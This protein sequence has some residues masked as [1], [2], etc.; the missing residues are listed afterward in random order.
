[1]CGTSAGNRSCI[2]CQFNTKNV[3]EFVMHLGIRHKKLLDFASEPMK[4]LF[5][6]LVGVEVSEFMDKVSDNDMDEPSED[7]LSNSQVS[8]EEEED[9]EGEE[10][11]ED[12]DE[13]APVAEEMEEEEDETMY[14]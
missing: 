4:N 1:M 7:V 10:E 5:N 3:F 6:K 13:G 8:L 14:T 11:E 2:Q 9:D 12:E